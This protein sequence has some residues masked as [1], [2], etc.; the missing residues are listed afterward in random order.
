MRP[1]GPAPQCRALGDVR[2][3]K[4]V[5]EFIVQATRPRLPGAISGLGT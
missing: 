3:P 5:L 1:G 2:A 4:F